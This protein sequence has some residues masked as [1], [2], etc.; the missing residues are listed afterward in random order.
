DL[1]AFVHVYDPDSYTDGRGDMIWRSALAYVAYSD[2]VVDAPGARVFIDLIEAKDLSVRQPPENFTE[3]LD[4]VTLNPDMPDW[5]MERLVTQAVP[6]LLGAWSIGTFNIAGVRVDAP[7]IDRLAIGDFTIS[8]L[9]IEGLRE[10]SLEGFEMALRGQFATRVGRF[11]IGN[12]IFGGIEGLKRLIATI[13]KGGEPDPEQVV[14]VVGFAEIID[15][16]LQTPDIENLSL[17]R[18]RG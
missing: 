11:S 7:G 9:S 15:F 14:P 17:G 12:M 4:T 13:D 3:F 8:D 18:F 16:Q 6:N 5:R 10:F 2:I 1:G